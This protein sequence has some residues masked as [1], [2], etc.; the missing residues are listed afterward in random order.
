MARGTRSAANPAPGSWRAARTVATCLCSASRHSGVH[1]GGRAA[2]SSPSSS[3]LSSSARS[4]LSSPGPTATAI[5]PVGRAEARASHP[6]RLPARLGTCCFTLL[7]SSWPVPLPFSVTR[8]GEKRT[9]PVYMRCPGKTR[10]D[11]SLGTE[12]THLSEDR[13]RPCAGARRSTVERRPLL[14]WLPSERSTW[15]RPSSF[16]CGEARH[17]R[18]RASR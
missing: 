3:A 12:G 18:W 17:V 15:F 5:P 14:S 9:I 2:G 11:R 8:S 4:I 13:W 10:N 6:T 1:W 7:P 16:P